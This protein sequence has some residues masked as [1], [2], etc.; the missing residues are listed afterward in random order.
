MPL[1]NLRELKL[2][3][4]E[5]SLA[6]LEMSVNNTFENLDIFASILFISL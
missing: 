1:G 4:A 6:E 2:V 3:L 5:V